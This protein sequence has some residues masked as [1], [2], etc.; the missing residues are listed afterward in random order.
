MENKKF[1]IGIVGT[2]DPNSLTQDMLE[3]AKKLG[4]VLSENNMIVATGAVGGFA[5]WAAQGAVEVGGVTLG[6]S[7]ASSQEEHRNRFRQPVD[8]LQTIIYTGFG[9]LGR[10]IIMARSVDAVVIGVGDHDSAHELL[11]ACEMGKP[12]YVLNHGV[13][14]DVLQQILGEVYTKV[15]V[16]D[17]IESI[18]Q[19]LKN[20]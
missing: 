16:H 8:Y 7:P 19:N 20:T 17:S 11:V 2:Q 9:Y 5:M 12:V 15:S 4:V 3:S 10:D 13:S 6:F 18:L 1:T 14:E